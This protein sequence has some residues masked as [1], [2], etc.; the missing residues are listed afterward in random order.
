MLHPPPEGMAELPASLL[1]ASLP[2]LL[3]GPFLA[4]LIKEDLI[5]VLVQEKGHLDP[6]QCLSFLPA[7]QLCWETFGWEPLRP[8]IAS[9]TGQSSLPSLC[10]LLNLQPGHQGVKQPAWPQTGLSSRIEWGWTETMNFIVFPMLLPSEEAPP[11]GAPCVN[12]NLCPSHTG[13]CHPVPQYRPGIPTS[14]GSRAAAR[15][16]LPADLPPMPFPLL[17]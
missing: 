12:P 2:A 10:Q 17:P 9:F 14:E 6:S 5:L 13:S 1:P 15:S 3:L 16:A 4:L 11:V 7:P 8:S